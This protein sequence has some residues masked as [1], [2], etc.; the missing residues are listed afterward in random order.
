MRPRRPRG[1]TSAARRSSPAWRGA[2][3]MEYLLLTQDPG[4]F[5]EIV[6]GI[7]SPGL[8]GKLHGGDTISLPEAAIKS[9]GSGRSD[10][11]R[12]LQSSIMNRARMLNY[13]FFDY[14]PHHD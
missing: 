8:T 14:D 12:L 3:A 4:H 13:P 1:R 9:D 2:R 11:D 6:D 7:T 5:A 10:L